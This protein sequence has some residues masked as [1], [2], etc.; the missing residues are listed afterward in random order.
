MA[1]RASSVAWHS[2]SRPRVGPGGGCSGLVRGH[3]V[4]SGTPLLRIEGCTPQPRRPIL[5]EAG[6]EQGQGQ[7]YL[8]HLPIY[9]TSL[10]A[11]P[12]YLH[13]LPIYTTSISLPP[14]P[15]VIATQKYRINTVPTPTVA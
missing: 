3:P 6:P 13:H 8:H 5:S 7:G 4:L 12:P 10:Y 1:A 2:G 14:P 15:F 11:P 9:T